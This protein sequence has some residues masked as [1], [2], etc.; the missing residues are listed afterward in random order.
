MT[1]N[2]NYECAKTAPIRKHEF[3]YLNFEFII[4]KNQTRSNMHKSNL[5]RGIVFSLVLVFFLAVCVNAQK[6]KESSK[7]TVAAIVNGVEISRADFD[8]TLKVAQEQFASIGAAQGTLPDTVDIEKEVIERLIGIELMLQDAQER[9][10][11]VEAAVID[12]QMAGFRNSFKTEE[13]FTGYMKENNITVDIVK[14]QITKQITLQQLQGVL[15]QELKEKN[16]ATQED[17]KAFYEANLEKFKHPD[18]IKASHILIKVEKDADEVTAKE[19]LS[20]IKDIRKKAVTG[21]DFAELAKKNSEGPTSV[22]GGDLGFFSKGMM[23]Q[24]F[25]TAAFALEPNEISEV[26]KTEFGYHIIKLI[27]KK[28]AGVTPFAEMEDKINQYLSQI[29][30]DQAQIQYSK[31]LREKATVEV[32]I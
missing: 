28:P 12:G 26:V 11:V 30:L 23:V 15:L 20:K 4:F 7:D 27:E 5:K 16:T 14:E 25:D 1:G 2:E 6:K 31:D 18:Q 8:N 29:Q 13:E 32:K 22:K 3:R 24:P 17:S 9:G 21:E 10:I 19:A